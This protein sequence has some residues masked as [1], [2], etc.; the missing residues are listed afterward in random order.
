[1]KKIVACGLVLDNNFGCPSILSG[2][3]E[4]LRRLYQDDVQLTYIQCGPVSAQAKRG[5]DF[6][7]MPISAYSS[8][9][10]LSRVFLPGIGKSLFP[11]AELD[12]ALRRI[13]EADVVVDLFGI[14]FC[15]RFAPKDAVWPLLQLRTMARFP[16]PYYARR[17]G[18][19]TVKFTSSYGPAEKKSTREEA[20]FASRH[21]FETMMAREEE[22]RKA[23]LGINAVRKDVPVSPDA[24]NLMPYQPP[25]PL[26]PPR[27]GVS[28]SYQIMRQWRGAE[29]YLSCMVR[30]CAHIT[31]QLGAEVVLIPN[32]YHRETKYSDIDVAKDVQKAFA[33]DGHQAQALGILDAGNCTALEIKDYIASC[34]LVVASRYHSCVA[35]LSS[36]VPLMVIGWH[37]KYDEL[38]HLYG[39]ERWLLSDAG[40]DGAG[41]VAMFQQLW[42]T[43]DAVR[44]EI[45]AHHEAVIAKALAAGERVLRD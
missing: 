2:F 45:A 3:R 5:M 31:K 42:D 30:L 14:C 39:Q 1:M 28:V 15:D 22:S 36:L 9:R 23:L 33:A 35:A 17:H 16:L 27:V 20:R 25:R 4:L 12:A 43:R 21:V 8:K 32:E 18:V 19:K 13:R 26:H 24:A 6:D 41:V 11:D 29:E 44:A 38:M 37:Y 40:C 10:F 7:I 34:D